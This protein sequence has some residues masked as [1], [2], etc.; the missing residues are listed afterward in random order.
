MGTK[1]NPL[2]K[3][4]EELDSLRRRVADLERELADAR[5]AAASSES[6]S[7]R[8]AAVVSH[9]PIVVWAVDRAGM[10]TLSEGLGLEAIGQSPGEVVGLNVFE[11]Y[12]DSPEVAGAVRR[13]LAGEEFTYV[14][15]VRGLAFKTWI[16][17]L[18]DAADEIVG[19]IGV[20]TDITPHIRDERALREAE[21]NLRSILENVPD[22]VF[23][24]DRQGVLLSMNHI[25]PHFAREQ[26]IGSNIYDYIRPEHRKNLTAAIE[27]ALRTGQPQRYEVLAKN[28]EGAESWFACRIGPIRQEGR[29]V[30][31]AGSAA[32]VT[33]RRH[34]EEKLRLACD[35][36]EG[37]IADRTAELLAANQRLQGEVEQRM[38]AEAHSRRQASILQSVLDS[39]GDGLIVADQDERLLLL[40]PAGA[41]LL[42]VDPA[43]AVEANWSWF[44]GAFLPDMVTPYPAHSRPIVRAIRGASISAEEIFFRGP[45]HPEGRWFQASARPLKDEQGAQ[46]GGVVV[47]RDITKQ[48]LAE[49]ALRKTEQRL[50]AFLDNTPS[51]IYLK[52]PQGR[53]LLSNQACQLLLE[54]TNDQIA[55]STDEDLF[56]RDVAAT[57]R[58]ND[59]AVLQAKKPFQFEEGAAKKGQLRTFLSVKFPL[60]D[61]DGEAYALCGISTDIT[62][63]K[64][65]EEELRSEQ[66]FMQQLLDAHERDRQLLAYE[67]HDG[68]VQYMSAALLHL[69]G[70]GDQQA[71][72]SVKARAA[73]ELATH[74]MRRA[75]A[76]GRRVLSGLRPPILDEAGVVLAIAYLIAEQSSPGEL[77]IDL[78]HRVSFDR[79][80]PLL[81]GTI[82]R[83]VQE[84]LNNVKRHS[85][86]SRAEVKLCERDGRLQIE[87][88]DWGVG[89]DPSQASKGQFGLEGIRKRAALMGGHAKIESS[90][91]QGT[92]VLIDLPLKPAVG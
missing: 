89:F 73:L 37:R 52:D 80:E 47:F 69:E 54:R 5:R 43:E 41:E 40:N 70:L 14:I 53:Y 45:A 67:I 78:T 1:T 17:P 90:P 66:R 63:R 60:C 25:G 79:L 9:A 22:T 33:E 56:P 2:A 16:S 26:L 6:S 44:K 30:A 48:K 76:E 15:D 51:V 55:G 46:Q 88:R 85:R 35:E 72:L 38:R 83:I 28:G 61:A 49:A 13:A 24:I 23:K 75:V 27:N 11:T 3:A 68:L 87:V 84:A 92:R 50:Q 77:Q 10:F 7:Q 81:E 42:G 39:M 91:G 65:A 62:E 58:A 36:L 64:R 59:L 12:S 57:F 71:K 19:A 8:L 21:E 32:D 31:L 82:F 86:A 4:K 18:R 29:I 74:L 34:A 20:S